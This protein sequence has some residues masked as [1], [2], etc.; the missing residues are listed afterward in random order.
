M[1]RPTV[2]VITSVYNGGRYLGPGIDSILSQTLNDFEYLIVDDA[3]TDRTPALLDEIAKH[4]SRIRVITN[5]ANIG[6][7][8][9]L[10]IALAQARGIYIARHDGDDIAL[11]QRL[12]EQREWLDAHP[13]ICLCGT[14]FDYI[15]GPGSVIHHDSRQLPI[16]TDQIAKRLEQKNCLVHSTIMFR[17]EHVRYREKFY[18]AQ[19]Y[20]LYLVLRSQGRQLAVLPRK[21][22]RYRWEAA[23]ISFRKRRQQALFAEQARRFYFQR[24]QN[25]RDEYDQW[26]EQ[27]ILKLPDRRNESAVSWED[28][29]TLHLRNGQIRLARDTYRQAEHESIPASK[30]FAFQI[31]LLIPGLYRLYRLLRYHD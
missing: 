17:N 23:A 2:S 18:Y 26:N 25:G 8:R 22:V 19:D 27:S 30:R 20:D 5:E 7:T 10:N 9:S 13:E 15:N 1:S 29:I 28:L 14:D 16:T 21:L 12:A 3:S 6:L 11:P 31:F 4:D 24:R